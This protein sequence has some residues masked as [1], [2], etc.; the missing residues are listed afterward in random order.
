MKPRR[1]MV[2]IEVDSDWSLM[3][4]YRFWKRGELKTYGRVLQ[5]QANV[6]RATKPKAK[7]KRARK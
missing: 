1:V 7:K 2:I 3:K 6:I 5:V 4:I